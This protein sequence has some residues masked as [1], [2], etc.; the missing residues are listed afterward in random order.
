MFWLGGFIV[1]AEQLSELQVTDWIGQKISSVLI[2]HSFT[3]VG[4]A[5]TL[6][7]LYFFSMYMFSSSTGHIVAL[8][9]PFFEAGDSLNCPPRLLISL[10]AYFGALSCCLV[11]R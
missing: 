10:I 5:V 2:L 11:R 6:A 1:I 7:V 8:V 9:G 3:P 4:G